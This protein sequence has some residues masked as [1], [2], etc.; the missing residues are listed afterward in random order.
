MSIALVALGGHALLP[1]GKPPS[2]EGEFEQAAQAMGAIADMLASG[3]QV[4]ITHGNGPQ[5]GHILLRSELAQGEAYAIPLSVAVAESEGEI[6]YIVQQTL[7]NELAA[8]N[9]HRPI[10]TV[11]TQVLVSH[12]DPAFQEPSKPI[13]PALSDEQINA[14]RERSVPVAQFAGSWRRVVPSPAP[15]SIIEADV[16]QQLC[17]SGVVVIAAGG[18]GIP[19]VSNNDRIA[20]VDAVVDKDL[21]SAV[22][23]I[24][25]NVSMFLILTDVDQVSLDLGTPGER[26]LLTMTVE[27][28]QRH[29]NDGQFPP[30]TMGPKVEGAIRFVRRTGNRAIITSVQRVASA[31]AGL[32]GTEITP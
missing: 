29:L 14:F 30:G 32:A 23:A 19:V 1:L 15:L 5:V 17:D 20:G 12:D 10:A 18:G 2:V 26:P 24:D 3:W 31:I 4:V 27:E 13:G 21:A 8:R 11:L 28:A 9:L 22:L 16:V 6:G 25:I 7:Y